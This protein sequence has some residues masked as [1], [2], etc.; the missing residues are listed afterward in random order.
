MIRGAYGFE[1]HPMIHHVSKSHAKNGGAIIEMLTSCKHDMKEFGGNKLGFKALNSLH[2]DK[3]PVIVFTYSRCFHLFMLNVDPIIYKHMTDWKL[4]GRWNSNPMTN[5][6]MDVDVNCALICIPCF[7]RCQWKLATNKTIAPT[8]T[9]IKPNLSWLKQRRA[10]LQARC[11][12]LCKKSWMKYCQICY[13]PQILDVW[14]SYLHL[15]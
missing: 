1:N 5:Q 4:P 6:S 11:Y 2:F 3:N 15:A 8:E 14:Y 13:Q 12:L 10:Q 7:C 9:K